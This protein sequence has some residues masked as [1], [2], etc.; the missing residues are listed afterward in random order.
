MKIEKRKPFVVGDQTF[1]SVRGAHRAVKV[2]RV[3]ANGRV[4]VTYLQ[5]IGGPRRPQWVPV[6]ELIR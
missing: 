2:V 4:Q 6:E 1:H 5:G 3:A